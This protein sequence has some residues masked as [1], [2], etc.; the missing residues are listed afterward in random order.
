VRKLRLAEGSLDVIV[1]ISTLDYLDQ[2]ADFEMC[3]DQLFRALRPG[4]MFM[5]AMDNPSNP[6]VSFRNV[7]PSM[8]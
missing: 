5:V 6:L 2:V 8:P 3:L 7:L 4:G 1:S